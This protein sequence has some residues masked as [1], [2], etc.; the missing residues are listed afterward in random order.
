ML[1]EIQ[2]SKYHDD[3]II[4]LKCSDLEK[5]FELS[6]KLVNNIKSIILF[7]GCQVYRID[8]MWKQNVIYR[9]RST[10]TESIMR[11]CS[12]V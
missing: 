9:I 3:D 12:W 11:C 5:G 8:G 10:L 2:L 1:N 7:S 6:F 4:G